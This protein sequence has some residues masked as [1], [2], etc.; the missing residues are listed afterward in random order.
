MRGKELLRLL[1]TAPEWSDTIFAPCSELAEFLEQ[2]SYRFTTTMPSTPHSY[3]LKRTWASEDAFVEALRKLRA[4]ERVKDFFYLD[5]GIAV[6]T[7]T[8]TNIGRWGR[9]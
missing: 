3:T 9:I 6:L 5:S 2:N 7:R 1:E 8:A 4:V